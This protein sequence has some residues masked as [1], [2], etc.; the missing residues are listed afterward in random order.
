MVEVG[1]FE[2]GEKLDKS[3]DLVEYALYV[4]RTNMQFWI[5]RIYW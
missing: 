4:V 5:R 2:E 1:H 3:S